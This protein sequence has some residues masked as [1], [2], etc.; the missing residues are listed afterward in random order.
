MRKIVLAVVVLMASGYG[1]AAQDESLVTLKVMAPETALKLAQATLKDC[2]DRGYQ[3]AVAVVDRFGNLQVTLRDR[4]AGAHTPETARRKAW[5]AVS[6]R[7]DTLSMSEFTAAGKEASGVRFVD[8]AMMVGGGV[9]VSA[10]GSIVGGVGVSGAP[11]GAADD[12][13]ARVGVAA[14]QEALDF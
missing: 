8:Q 5:T 1:A 13:C 6:F 7:T 9:P 14:V 12:E 10:A 11:G 3:V 2:R 4:F